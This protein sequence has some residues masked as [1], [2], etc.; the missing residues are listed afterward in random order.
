MFL[1]QSTFR[2]G[3]EVM[4]FVIGGEK[5]EFDRQHVE[6]TMKKVHPESIQ[7]HLVELL[8]TVYPPKQ[9]FAEVTGR[10]RISF[11]TQEA[12]RVLTKLGF[13]CREAG[14]RTDDAFVQMPIQVDEPATSAPSTLVNR[15]VAVESVLA[16]AHLAIA[17]LQR[18]VESLEAYRTS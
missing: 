9:V 17:E 5:Y 1:Y 8:G 16:T 18:R 13:V 3:V 14:Q 15:L 4:K 10:S 12:L 7:K 11:T 6:R 2:E